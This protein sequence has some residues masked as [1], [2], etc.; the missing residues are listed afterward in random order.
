MSRPPS[1]R[2]APVHVR[3]PA[4]SA[5]LGP[6]FDA[7]A[8]ALGLHDDVMVQVCDSGLQVDVAGEGAPGTAGELPGGERHLVVRALRATFA[9]LGGQP[10]GL[11]VSCANRIPQGR[12][13]GS[14]AAA[15]VAGVLAAR[16]LVPGVWELSETL[17]LA[18][19]LDGHPD[20]VAGA[21]LGGL[22]ACWT[23]SAGEV[24]ATRLPLDPSVSPVV[25]VPGSRQGTAAARKLLPATLS[26]PDAAWSAGRAALLSAA[27]GGRLDLLLVAT[28]D[29]LHQPFR[30]AGLPG[31]AALLAE[32]RAEGVAATLSGSGPAVLALA[33]SPAQAAQLAHRAPPGWQV[34]PTEVV[35]PA[36]L[37]R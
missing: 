3:V 20:N 14:S 24:Q 22:T 23:G 5:N 2:A 27:L 33:T 9:A 28:E 13:L 37:L 18:A 15:I 25:F 8:L 26:H 21:L 11:A 7:L 1:F 16:A 31:S 36:A 34:I 35:G 17:A 4:T 29:R 19:R 30:L 32:L 10:R 6:G 12:G